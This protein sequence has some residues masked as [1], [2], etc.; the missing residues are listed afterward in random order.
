MGVDVGR[1]LSTV[2]S[3]LHHA[4]SKEETNEGRRNPSAT[5]STSSHVPFRTSHSPYLHTP[6]LIGNYRRTRDSDRPKITWEIE[7]TIVNTEE[8]RSTEVTSRG[9]K[10]GKCRRWGSPCWVGEGQV[11]GS[12]TTH[13]REILLGSGRLCSRHRPRS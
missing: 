9:T 5:H 13:P 10:D 3:S 2:T 1:Y 4:K 11:Q 12:G 6:N 8:G 7:S